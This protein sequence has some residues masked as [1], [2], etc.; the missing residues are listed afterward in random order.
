MYGRGRVFNGVRRNIRQTI[1]RAPR[2]YHW[3][4]TDYSKGFSCSLCEASAKVCIAVSGRCYHDFHGG[5]IKH[6]RKD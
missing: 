6:L 4:V 1:P 2:G 5:V 3:Q